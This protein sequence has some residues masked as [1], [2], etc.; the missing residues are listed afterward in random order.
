M[1]QTDMPCVYKDRK[2]TIMTAEEYQTEAAHIRPELTAIARRYLSDD[3]GAEDVVQDALLRLWTMRED[4]RSPMA[5]LA[6]VIVRHLCVN[7]LRRTRPTTEIGDMS[8]ADDEGDS[9]EAVERMM[10]IIATLPPVQQTILQLRHVDGMEMAE[11][12]R[13]T[14]MGEAAVR[15]ALSRARLAVRRKYMETYINNV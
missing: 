13:L 11:I 3:V 6:R 2:Q 7:M 9:H 5:P 4:L 10:A 15:K 12:A 1:S 8:V 14:G